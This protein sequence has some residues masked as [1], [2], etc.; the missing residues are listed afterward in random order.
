[1]SK[2]FIVGH[3]GHYGGAA[4]ELAHQIKLWH[5]S[6]PEIEL[7]LI[8][9]MENCH[10]EPMYQEMLDIGIKYHGARDY[11]AISKEDA[12]I[13]FCSKEYLQDLDIINRQT[14]RV[15]WVNC[16]TF[17]FDDEMRQGEKG[18]ISHFLYQ[19]DEVLCG[20]KHFLQE[21]G[22]TGRFMR[23]SPY[24]DDSNMD[25]SVKDQEKTH[26]GRISRQDA[27]KFSINTLH[28]YEYIVSPKMKEGHFLGF[29]D[30]SKAK[31]GKPFDWIK[32]YTSHR[33]LPVKDF[34]NQVDFI[35][36]PMDTVENL[37]RIG[38]EAMFSGKPLVVDNKGGWK[39]LIEHGHSGFLCN[40]ARDF[41]Y[42][43]SRLAYEPELRSMVAQN[44]RKRA[45]EMA[46][47]EVSTESWRK[48]FESVFN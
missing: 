48:V 42:W 15:M 40:H 13:N 2:L 16:M 26:I 3:P 21:L 7:N 5:R 46:S 23:F 38:F 18:L 10:N 47:L 25:F 28:I 35:V 39:T 17:L 9:T 27:D 33:V 22:T 11:S 24:F 32:T 4:S 12:I 19:R 14:N 8:P 6:F 20:H 29:D 44:A 31:I 1:M 36:Q 30:R 37:P 34:Y 45:M 43:G 41:I